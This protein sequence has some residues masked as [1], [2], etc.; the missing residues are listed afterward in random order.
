MKLSHKIRKVVD[1][2]AALSFKRALGRTIHPLPVSRFMSQIDQTELKRLWKAYGMPG[3]RKC[4]KYVE[5]E[6]FLKINIRRVQAQLL[7]VSPLR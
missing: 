1:P 4:P 7:R 5:A 2:A 6:R 3:T